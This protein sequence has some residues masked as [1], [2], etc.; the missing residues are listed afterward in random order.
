MTVEVEAMET[1][2]PDLLERI[3]RGDR[4]R[5]LK[6]GHAVGVL[7]PAVD[8]D[9][10]IARTPQQIADAH[11]ALADI[12]ALSKRLNLGPFDFEEFK[13]DRDAGRR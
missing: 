5:L 7:I 12:D 8:T 9:S 3:D 13:A 11:A 6:D 4:V 1:T 2:I 10:R